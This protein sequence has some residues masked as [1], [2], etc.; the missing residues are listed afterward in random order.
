MRRSN[1][2]IRTLLSLCG[3]LAATQAMA[4]ENGRPD[5]GRRAVGALGFDVDGPDGPTPPLGICSGFVVSDSAFVTAAHCIVRVQP[6]ARSWAVTLEGG[7]P[8]APVILPGVFDRSPPA[9]NVFDFPF[10]VESVTATAV[11]LHPMYD[12]ATQANDV[13]VL[14]FPGGT[15]NVPPIRV[16]N[17]QWMEFLEHTGVL[18][19]LPVLLQGYGASEDIDGMGL[20]FLIPGY[21]QWGFTQVSAT[22]AERISYAP[23]ERFDARALPGDSGSPQRILGRAVS[24]TSV[25]DSQRLD[26]PPVRAFLAPYFGR[27]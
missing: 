9:P 26:T 5:P 8:E 27:P 15:F 2:T 13:A 7:S 12:P 24:V 20:R 23:T 4:I 11:T 18:Y 25:G 10:L 19:Y 17:S 14:E 3:L 6:F 21:R 22:S 16:V 1:R